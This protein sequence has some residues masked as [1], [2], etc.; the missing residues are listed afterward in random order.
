MQ[1]DKINV[2][3]ITGITGQDGSFLTELLL[4]KGYIVWG[5]IRKSSNFNTERINHLYNNPNLNLRYGDMIDQNGLSSIISEIQNKYIYQNLNRLEIYNLAAMSH[6]K[7][8]FD[9]AEYTANVD[10]LGTLRLLEIIRKS[11]I[12]NKIY[13]YQASTSELFG[14]V[15]EIPQ[16][17]ET[18]FNPQSPYALAKLYAFWAVKHYRETYNIFA[19]NGILFNHE[20]ERRG[21]TF[22]TKKITEGLNQILLG[23]EKELV[24][25]NLNS[26]RDWGYAK[27]YVEGMWKMLQI[28]KPDDFI[29]ATNETHSVREFVELAFKLKGIKIR[30]IGEGLHE[31]GINSETGDV[32]IRVSSNYFRPSDVDFLL[33]D[34]SKAKKEL[35]WEP[36]C[37]FLELIQRMVEH[38]CKG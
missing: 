14:S 5:I 15:K 11:E 13:F 25:G 37:T 24:L 18:P 29:L 23:K 28:E 12:S 32:I 30:W 22:I 10:A 3:L 9:M 17:E 26:K 8:S 20:S 35:N 36:K 16:T 7:V 27:D 38:D 21:S 4:E 34:Y 2:A 1:I 31:K 6:V 33:G 19:C